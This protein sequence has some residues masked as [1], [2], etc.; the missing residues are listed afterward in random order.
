MTFKELFEIATE[1]GSEHLR[2]FAKVIF[3]PIELGRAAA[4]W[5]LNAKSSTRLALQPRIVVFLLLNAFI[6]ATI[7]AAIPHRPPIADR[8]TVAVIVV[9]VWMAISFC[10][11]I[12]C[13]WFG[14]KRRLEST[15]ISMMMLLSTVYVLSNLLTFLLVGAGNA[16]AQVDDDSFLSD[17]FKD[18]GSIIVLLQFALI[19]ALAPLTLRGLHGFSAWRFVA[20]AIVSGVTTIVLSLSTLANGGC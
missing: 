7:G 3:H 13:R 16:L 20:V 2:W 14:S 11:H 19:L 9:F 15:T 8:A 1:Y 10:V 4:A 12:C 17:A 18:P 5:S 6:G